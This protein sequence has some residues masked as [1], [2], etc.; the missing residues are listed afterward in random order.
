MTAEPDT[1]AA[2]GDEFARAFEQF[3]S[4]L[5][6]D[7]L[8]ALQPSGPAA[9]YSTWVVVWLLVYQRLHANAPLRDAV[10]E[11]LRSADCLP[12][13]RRLAEGTL[14]ANTAAYSRARSRLDPLVAEQVADHVYHTL[15]AAT[16]PSWGDRR[17]FILDG[18][19]LT[20]TPTPELKAAFPPATNQHGKSAWPVCQLLVAHELASGCAIRP[21][22]G[23]MYGPA[24]V[25]ELELAR[26]LL[27][28]LPHQAVLLA[29]SN[30]GV[31]AFAHAAVAAGHDV[32]L[33]LTGPRFRSLLKKARPLGPGSWE[34]VWRPSRW[35]RQAHPELA[36]DAA[37]AVRLH[38]VKVSEQL[39]LWLVTTLAD[40]GAALAGLYRLR[41]DVETD[42][43]DVKVVLKTEQVGGRSVAMVGKELALSVVAYNLVVQ[44][45][46]L[47]AAKAG[48][49]PRRLS[50]TGT[51]SLVR[52]VLL[53]AGEWTAE[54]WAAKFARVL[55]A[56]GQR[57]V[58]HRPGRSYPRQVLR[59]RRKHPERPRQPPAQRPPADK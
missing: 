3:R 6:R 30:F 39:T 22:T 54:Q 7:T 24:A 20:L 33:R 48:V 43:R 27:P 2:A 14:S 25:S 58:P 37:V 1:A 31:F 36:A 46:R 45:R 15:V 16:P 23:P 11:L 34:L 19:T 52:V 42:I 38:E 53:A 28:R 56:A 41:L 4:L 59:R 8:N 18:T 9:V 44:V 12:P 26:R 5:D 21:E 13:H 29:D 55:R 40:S 10:A 32:V 51:W 17:V 50:F 35:D 57:K 49:R 47:A